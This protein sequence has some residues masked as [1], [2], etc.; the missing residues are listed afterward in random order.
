MLKRVLSPFQRF[1][2]TESSSGVL[3]FLA[4]AVAILW[5]NSSFSDMYQAI[6]QIQ[7]GF[8]NDIID[9]SKPLIL[10]INDG[11]MAVFFFL[12]GLEIKRELVKGELNT[13]RKASFPLFAAIGGMLVPVGL[14]LALN[15]NPEAADAWAIPMATDIAFSLAILSLLGKRVP[16]SLKVFL[17]AFA[18]VD[19]LGAVLIIA[20]FYS[21][22]INWDLILY[23][24]GLLGVLFLLAKYNLYNTYLMIFVSI[25]IWFLF[26]KSGIHPT[27]AGVL[28]AFTIP[29]KKKKEAETSELEKLEHKL[30]GVVA[31]FIMPIFALSNAGIAFSSGTVLDTDLSNIIV[32]SLLF[33]KLIGVT[34]FSYIGIWTGLVDLPKDINFLKI[35][36]VSLL[37]GVG[38]T[39]SIFIANL[40]FAGNPAL[41][42]S[43]K[44][45]ILIGSSISGALGF[46]VLRFK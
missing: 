38:F 28:I 16:L 11:L 37:A 24:F 42:D 10:W 39:M 45:G 17:T 36:G 40:A 7:I 35:I 15:T 20:L 25:V 30:H 19:D 2:R 41:L 22:S 4:T 12:I 1:F 13:L 44:L 23:A 5:A 18:I 21:G 9:F 34:L 32:L 27:I 8:N 26:L 6:W 33:G 3:L 14:F 31:Y 29:L 46:I 43:S